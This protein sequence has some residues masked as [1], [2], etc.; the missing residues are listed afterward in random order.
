MMVLHAESE[1]ASE[2]HSHHRAVVYVFS[3]RLP[4]CA[5]GITRM[6]FVTFRMRVKEEA[7]GGMG[8]GYD[9]AGYVANSTGYLNP[10]TLRL[11]QH[12][13]AASQHL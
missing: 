4:A 13:T 9:N 3:P 1:D 10:F 6:T 12:L 2:R 11:L 8:I 7:S 5:H